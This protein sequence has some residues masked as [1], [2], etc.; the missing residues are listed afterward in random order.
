M[1]VIKTGAIFKTLRFGSVDSGNFGIYIT[2]SAV[3]NAPER[4]VERVS[5]PGR[6]GALILDQGHFENVSVTYPAGTFAASQGEFSAN[7]AE[8]RNAVLS[9]L[10]YQR[11][12]D[13]YNT[14]EYRMANASA[15][16]EAEPS[17]N[18]IAGEFE[19][20]FDCKPQRFLTAGESETT[21]AASGDAITNPTLFESE[22]LLV[23]DGYG[24]VAF[25]GYEM[26]VFDSGIGAVTIAENAQM[27]AGMLADEVPTWVFN[28][29]TDAFKTGDTITVSGLK[30]MWMASVASGNY[31]MDWTSITPSGDTQ[32]ADYVRKL[33]TAYQQ[34]Y[35]NFVDFSLQVGTNAT[36]QIAYSST[37][38]AYPRSGS[39]A[40]GKSE[41]WTGT[42]TVTHDATAGTI[43]VTF[44]STLNLAEFNADH[45]WYQ[46][47][48]VT[49][50]V[51]RI[52]GTS[53]K[54][55]VSDPIY[56]DTEIGEAYTF[57]G[58][59]QVSLNSSVSIGAELPRLAPGANT[60][61]FDNTFDS[62]KIVPRW[63]QL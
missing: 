29:N 50:D 6:N 15:G 2:G 39:P 22:P 19:L 27:N 11:L 33:R 63:W 42:A 7:L 31:T 59:E 23:L 36:I 26:E 18:G 62:V 51:T 32:Y 56:I 61:T 9:Q 45:A 57:R 38:G 44:A 20:V 13:D 55:T 21:I 10:G 3:Y 28:Y 54:P 12:E 40:D 47:Q 24:K 49:M 60:V 16:F 25:N 14:G 34:L 5:V 41:S 1:A 17:K 35:V 37:I 53:T 58:G 30:I 52:G 8:F 46:F 48:I 4:A 43:T